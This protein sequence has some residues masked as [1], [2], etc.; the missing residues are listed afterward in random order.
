MLIRRRSSFSPATIFLVKDDLR[1]ARSLRSSDL[2]SL[3][4][5]PGASR[6]LRLRS[7]LYLVVA[8]LFTSS[9]VAQVLTG[10]QGR[11]I[12]DLIMSQR[13][14]TTQE[15][16]DAVGITRATLQDWIKKRKFAAPK[17]RR[18]GKVGVRLWTISD[19]GRLK[20]TKSE[21]YQ[22]K[23]VKRKRAAT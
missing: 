9:L 19:I 12:S 3:P 6:L 11:G 18:L 5:L 21:I 4:P 7:A 8:C 22:E 2:W 15:A 14:Y 10:C 1:I 13:T 17:L 16:A 23:R 20:K